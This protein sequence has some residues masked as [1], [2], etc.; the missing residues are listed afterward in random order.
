M[1]IDNFVDNPVRTS[2]V[3]LFSICIF[4]PHGFTNM[5]KALCSITISRIK[6]TYVTNLNFSHVIHNI[7][8]HVR[9]MFIKHSKELF[10][11]WS[12]VDDIVSL[13]Q[14]HCI[15]KIFVTKIFLVTSYVIRI[16][17]YLNLKCMYHF[18]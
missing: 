18:I 14:L 10:Y 6:A 7:E 11:Q 13:F 17:M 3:Q 4:A 12:S 15:S 8:V 5:A 2:K 1:A 16:N 9:N